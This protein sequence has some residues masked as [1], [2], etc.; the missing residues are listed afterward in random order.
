MLEADIC[1]KE[2]NDPAFQALTRTLGH[3]TSA[4]RSRGKLVDH[5][6][7]L[8]Q[9]WPHFPQLLTKKLGESP[10]SKFSTSHSVPRP[11][12]GL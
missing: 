4:L 9:Y 7:F 8:S 6:R 11:V 3:R 1:Y 5:D 12:V 2:E 10:F